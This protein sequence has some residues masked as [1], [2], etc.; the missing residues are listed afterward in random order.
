M[1]GVLP[2]SGRSWFGYPIPLSSIS[3][4]LQLIFLLICPHVPSTYLLA[5][6]ILVLSHR[7]AFHVSSCRPIQLPSFK[8]LPANAIITG[9]PKT[10]L[11]LGKNNLL[12][13][14]LKVSYLIGWQENRSQGQAGMVRNRG[15]F[16][17]WLKEIRRKYHCTMIPFCTPSCFLMPTGT[18]FYH[19]TGILA[20]HQE[21]I[22]LANSH[23][24][25]LSNFS[26]WAGYEK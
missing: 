6:S 5:C 14:Y 4:L 13:V 3:P 24:V 10:S 1:L 26:I 16:W 23:L 12:I 25:V 22:F 18:A 7:P 9:E 2:I 15:T 21:G 11:C 8:P 17:G 19:T 20:L